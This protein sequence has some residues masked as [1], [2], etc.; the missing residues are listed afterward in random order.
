MNDRLHR[1][2]FFHLPGFSVIST[3]L[4]DHLF[5]DPLTHEQVLTRS[6]WVHAASNVHLHHHLHAYPPHTLSGRI[7]KRR[8]SIAVLYAAPASHHIWVRPLPSWRG[9]WIVPLLLLNPTPHQ[10]LF[11][12][13]SHI[14]RLSPP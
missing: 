14:D 7:K 12:H 6:V 4:V 9:P 3:S 5:F 11:D 1:R 13:S 10:T 8:R 2:N